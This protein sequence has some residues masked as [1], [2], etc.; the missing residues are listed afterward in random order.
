MLDKVMK[1]VF[2]IEDD[3]YLAEIIKEEL[4]ES[5]YEVKVALSGNSAIQL[6]QATKPDLVILDMRLPD[7][8]GLIILESIGI[9]YSEAQV[10]VYTAYEEYK[11]QPP[12]LNE[13]KFCNFLLKPLPMETI[14]SEVKRTIGEP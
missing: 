12:S 1:K 6:L 10:I 7:I 3:K 4:E 13:K 5:G 14:V 8:D 2:I 11:K 9:K